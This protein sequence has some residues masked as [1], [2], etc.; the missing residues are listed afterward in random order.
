MPTKLGLWESCIDYFNLLF[1]ESEFLLPRMKIIKMKMLKRQP[2]KL[3]RQ[4][5]EI[6]MNKM[7]SPGQT[8]ALVACWRVP[9]LVVQSV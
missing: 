9:A 4:I 6:Q 8:A 7:E 3:V 1:P 5:L 2:E